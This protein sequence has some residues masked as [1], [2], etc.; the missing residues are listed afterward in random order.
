MNTSRY[1]EEAPSENTPKD[2][3]GVSLEPGLNVAYNRS[4]E[5]KKGKLISVNKFKW[6][7]VAEHANQKKWWHL[8]CEIEVQEDFSGVKSILQNI[9]SII[10]I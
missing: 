4:G 3:Y 8:K 9:N 5:V 2:N 7:V 6:V 10:V 1:Q